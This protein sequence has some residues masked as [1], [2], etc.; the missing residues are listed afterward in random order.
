MFFSRILDQQVEAARWTKVTRVGR[1]VS[2]SGHGRP[3]CNEVS[4]LK[5]PN[6]CIFFYV[7]AGCGQ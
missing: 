4:S 6:R 1:V 2:L 5:E 3:Q 7:L